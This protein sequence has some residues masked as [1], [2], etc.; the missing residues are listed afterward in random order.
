MDV[1][2]LEKTCF[3]GALTARNNLLTIIRTSD[4]FRINQLHLDLLKS[5]SYWPIFNGPLSMAKT[6]Q[7]NP[8]WKM[9]QNWYISDV[10]VDHPDEKSIITY[11][12]SYYHYFNEQEM[13][14]MT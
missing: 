4:V 14:E 11:V 7:K 13:L 5:L 9:W 1:V 10:T 8:M 3:G 6:C 12:V 2:D